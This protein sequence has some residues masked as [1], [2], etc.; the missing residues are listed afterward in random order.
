VHREEAL[1]CCVFRVGELVTVP[2]GGR[3]PGAKDRT[4]RRTEGYDAA[5]QRRRASG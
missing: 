5:W 3:K 2:V 1:V 4:K